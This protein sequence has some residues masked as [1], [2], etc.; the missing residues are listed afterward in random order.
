MARWLSGVLSK[1]RP[2]PG[3]EKNKRYVL[4]R[5]RAIVL[6]SLIALVSLFVAEVRESHAIPAFARK[7]DA[8]CAMCHYPVV[9]RLNNF[10]QMYR[11]MGYRTPAEYDKP[12]ELTN[13]SNFLSARIKAQ[14]G[15]ENNKGTVERSEFRSPDVSLFYAGALSRNFSA[16]VHVFANN[17]TNV[18][19]HG[20]LMGNWGTP[21]NM[22]MVRIGQ[23]HMLSQEG[24]GGFDRPT[25]ISINPVHSLVLT[26]TSSLTGG[27]ALAH[28][29]DLRQKG[30]E[31]AYLHGPGK[32]AV[33]VSNGLNQTGSGSTNIGDIDPQKDIMVFYEHLLDAIASGFTLFYYNGTTHGTA[34]FSPVTASTGPPTSIS[35]QFNYSR[36]GFNLSKIFPVGGYGFFELQGGYVRSY[37]NNPVQVGPDVQGN[38]YYVESQQYITGPE[39]TFF[40]RYSWI[41]FDAARK[42][43][44]RKD[45]T[46]GVV[47][48]LQTWLRITAEYS[49]TDNRFR[50]L[51]GHLALMELQ[52]NW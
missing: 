39:L 32:L 24:V 38:A 47:T 42:N 23:M 18:D 33:Q 49:Y 31:L 43:S 20:H 1:R 48:P 17:S 36:Y 26:R 7:Y 37:D 11:R 40:E 29:F 9:P 6:L 5:L 3:H 46:V 12:Q 51:T 22:F 44:A 19:V 45:Y 2:Y 25:S 50:G 16:W 15:Y 21:E 10:G 35:N 14:F 41:D 27:S 8:D 30:V 34:A 13:V 4:T 52:S 28:N